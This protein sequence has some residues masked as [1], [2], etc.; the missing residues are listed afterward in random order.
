[1]T[2]SEFNEMPQDQ[3]ASWLVEQFMALY[4]DDPVLRH[5]AFDLT[6]IGILQWES[7]IEAVRQLFT[8]LNADARLRLK[9]AM[10]SALR[11][12][13][14]TSFPSSGVTDLVMLVGVLE[15]HES[16]DAVV[17][18]TADTGKWS[19]TVPTLWIDALS[20]LKGLRGSEASYE[21]VR[22]IVSAPAFPDRYAFDALSS[23]CG[24]HAR[25]LG[26]GLPSP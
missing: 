6:G 11:Q 21:S 15:A 20:V 16:L 23:T 3:M 13:D 12:V 18:V 19:A 2:L 10:G 26:R 8:H 1:M 22:K 17:S 9:R 4:S 7:P 25:T 24:R 5:E 14:P